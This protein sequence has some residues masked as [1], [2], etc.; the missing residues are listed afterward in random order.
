MWPHLDSLAFLSNH[1][2]SLCFAWSHQVA[3]RSHFDSLRITW[4]PLE[5]LDPLG[6][7]GF[8]LLSL[9]LTW[10]HLVPLGFTWSRWVSLGSHLD[11][12]GLT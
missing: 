4:P 6:V 10:L 7:T 2:V 1:L 12:P 5:S 8:H 3:L 9:G 11:P